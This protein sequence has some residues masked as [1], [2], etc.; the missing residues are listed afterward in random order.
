MRV[1]CPLHRACKVI[2]SQA[3]KK[4]IKV[5]IGERSIT[6]SIRETR[7]GQSDVPA[8]LIDLPELFDRDGIYSDENGDFKDNPQ[9]L[10][11]FAKPRCSLRISPTGT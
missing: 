3:L 2:Q 9:G 10:S 4:K 1:I 8:Y 6:A 5:K 7:L 11:P